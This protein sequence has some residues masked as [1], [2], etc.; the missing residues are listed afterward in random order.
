MHSVK[1]LFFRDGVGYYLCIQILLY[2]KKTLFMS[3]SV[4]TNFKTRLVALTS[5]LLNF[6]VLQCLD[7]FLK[8]DFM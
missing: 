7:A 6:N 2:L 4:N 3:L 8:S 1:N 5:T